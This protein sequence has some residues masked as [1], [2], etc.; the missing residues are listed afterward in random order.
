MVITLATALVA[1]HD[2]GFLECDTDV[3]TVLNAGILLC[4]NDLYHLL[5]FT[6]RTFIVLIC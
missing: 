3:E 1:H 2:V 4:F 6:A 5:V